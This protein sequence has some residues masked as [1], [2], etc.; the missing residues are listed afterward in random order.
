VGQDAVLHNRRDVRN[1]H[2]A[3]QFG[4]PRIQVR[5]YP[6]LRLIALRESELTPQ[7]IL[8][9]Y[10]NY[11]QAPQRFLT[12]HVHY[13]AHGFGRAEPTRPTLRR[14]LLKRYGKNGGQ[15]GN[16]TIDTRILKTSN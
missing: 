8:T 3:M 4:Y 15:G 16:R 13:V 12:R 14:N 9:S 11:A 2:D 7:E 1:R 10:C 6:N 5:S